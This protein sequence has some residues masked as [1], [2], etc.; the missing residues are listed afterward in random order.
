MDTETNLKLFR[1]STENQDFSEFVL[2]QCCCS[3][4]VK[5]GWLLTITVLFQLHKN[6][7]CI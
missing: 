7:L 1:I 2:N 5:D 3:L 4:S 6:Q